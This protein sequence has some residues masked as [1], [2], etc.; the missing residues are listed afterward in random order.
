MGQ[1]IL[2]ADPRH[3]FYNGLRDFFSHEMPDAL[4]EVKTSL[5][6]FQTSIATRTYN[7]MIVNQ[8][9]LLGLS[10]LTGLQIHLIVLAPKPDKE[11][12][13]TARAFHARAYLGNDHSEE[14][15]RAAL[16]LE[17]G[18]FLLDPAF[19]YRMF[20]QIGKNGRQPLRL[21][22]LTEREREVAELRNEGLTYKEIAKRLYIS[23]S[24]VKQHLVSIRKKVD[25][26]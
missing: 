20:E 15:L 5:A 13:L 22:Q 21:E 2:V 23:A 10:H 3:V 12:F 16:R 8:S 25:K 7:L 19:D 1:R 24:T 11:L 26:T 6:S 14:I 18:Q 17:P 9:F 4:I